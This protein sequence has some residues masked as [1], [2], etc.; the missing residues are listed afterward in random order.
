LS[1][2]GYPTKPTAT[3]FVAPQTWEPVELVISSAAPRI[4]ATSSKAPF[5]NGLPAALSPLDTI[6]V[7]HFAF[8]SDGALS[9]TADAHTAGAVED[10]QGVTVCLLAGPLS[11]PDGSIVPHPQPF[12]PR[13]AAH[14][15]RERDAKIAKAPQAVVG[16]VSGKTSF[17]LTLETPSG[18]R[19]RTYTFEKVA[20]FSEG[21]ATAPSARSQH[22]AVGKPPPWPRTLSEE[23]QRARK[24]RR[25]SRRISLLSA[26]TRQQVTQI[27]PPAWVAL[28]RR[29]SELETRTLV[30]GEQAVLAVTMSRASLADGEPARELLVARDGER[31]V[32]S[33]L[34]PEVISQAVR[35]PSLGDGAMLVLTRTQ[36]VG[37][38]LSPRILYAD[39]ARLHVLAPSS[40]ELVS[41]GQLRLGEVGYA[42]LVDKHRVW[43]VFYQARV[44]GRGC[45]QVRRD[46]AWSALYDP[47]STK[48]SERSRI[49]PGL[50]G[51][52]SDLPNRYAKVEARYAWT[53]EDLVRGG[54]K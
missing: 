14:C 12:A 27:E 44:V 7:R 18:S 42:R 2:V 22:E 1:C 11:I 52:P 37:V 6:P 21:E 43:R 47:Q 9:F 48:L 51:I 8:A 28:L 33:P 49:K 24:S 26:A 31:W 41:R 17:V 34:M 5:H 15:F 32:S 40:G 23:L 35:A 29:S 4:E 3:Y 39:E 46:H 30:S 38:N 20:E 54:C 45:L 10:A 36:N 13:A 50:T 25:V 16:E 19:R 53:G